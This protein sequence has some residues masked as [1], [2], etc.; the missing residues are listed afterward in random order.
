MKLASARVF[1]SSDCPVWLAAKARKEGSSVSLAWLAAKAR[2]D[3][4][5]WFCLDAKARKSLGY[6]YQKVTTSE[7]FY[8]GAWIEETANGTA[9]LVIVDHTDIKNSPTRK[10]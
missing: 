2:L 10:A 4:E 8:H 6:T 7:P 3:Q 1:A 5:G 9:V